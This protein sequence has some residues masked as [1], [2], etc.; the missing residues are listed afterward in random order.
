MEGIGHGDRTVGTVQAHSEVWSA[1]LKPGE[2]SGGPNGYCGSNAD[3][4]CWVKAGQDS[5]GT[6][7]DNDFVVG[8]TTYFVRSLRYGVSGDGDLFLTLDQSLSSTEKDSLTP[9][10]GSM[11]F[12]RSDASDHRGGYRW[13]GHDRPWTVGTDITVKLTARS[14][15]LPDR[16]YN[17]TARAI[18]FPWRK[19]EGAIGY[20]VAWTAGKHKGP[21]S[22][23]PDG[24]SETRIDN[25]E[26][27]KHS[28]TGLAA[29]T[30]YTVWV[31]A[32]R[33]RTKPGRLRQW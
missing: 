21:R 26:T 24:T 10:I 6:L 5:Y 32:P 12:A 7:S 22:R 20:R 16:V 18:D 4:E 30:A 17:V 8:S 33:R 31:T 1:T 27:T 29:G 13:T 25:G 15:P 19:A 3:S 2:I 23:P 14:S 28:I 9:H 11:Q